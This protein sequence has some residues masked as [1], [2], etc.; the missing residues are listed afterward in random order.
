MIVNPSK[1]KHLWAG[2]WR[3]EER[4]PTAPTETAAPPAGPGP[5]P[6]GP[7]EGSPGPAWRSSR[8]VA[9]YAAFVV[10]LAGGGFLAGHAS[11]GSNS[12]SSGPSAQNATLPATAAAPVAPK[13][14]QTRAP[15]NR[16]AASP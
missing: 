6:Q 9:I 14:G 10:A 2:D 5:A 12:S 4:P 15:A 1:N 7:P 16:A 3:E 13:S 8:A 11:R